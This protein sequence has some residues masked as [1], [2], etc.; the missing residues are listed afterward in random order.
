METTPDGAKA[1]GRS[2]HCPIGAL[3]YDFPALSVQ[4]HPEF[5]EPYV[6]ALIE[7]FSGKTFPNDVAA[8]ARESLKTL[9][10]D[11]ERT[12]RWAAE[13]FRQHLGGG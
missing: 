2:D 12:A 5:T 11:S 13:F 3:T 4:Y 9:A 1:L 6:T 10:V 8:Q 7:M